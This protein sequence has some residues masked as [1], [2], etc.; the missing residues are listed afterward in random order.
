MDSGVPPPLED[1]AGLGHG[2][3]RVVAGEP[4]ERTCRTPRAPP[5]R[6]V[7]TAASIGGPAPTLEPDGHASRPAERNGSLSQTRVA[8]STCGEEWT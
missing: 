8:R 2:P 1:V 4:A 5:T 6:P 7:Q 3:W